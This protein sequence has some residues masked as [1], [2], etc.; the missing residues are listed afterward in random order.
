GIGQHPLWVALSA[1]R[2]LGDRPRLTGSAAF[3]A[4]WASARLRRPPPRG[5]RGRGRRRPAPASAR[6]TRRA[7]VRTPRATVDLAPPAQGRDPCVMATAQV[8]DDRGLLPSEAREP[9]FSR[10][11]WR[12]EFVDRLRGHP[13]RKWLVRHGLRLG[14][15]VY[16]GEHATF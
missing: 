2:R 10:T 4:G 13:S 3:L 8:N 1:A 15:E 16:I 5:P 7:G 14:R 12:R 11:S 9:R 6:G